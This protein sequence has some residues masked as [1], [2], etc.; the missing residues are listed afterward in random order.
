MPTILALVP[1]LMFGTRIEDAAKRLGYR[2]VSLSAADDFDAVMDRDK[3]ALVIVALDA[4]NWERAVPAA[5]RAGARVLAFG[6]HKNVELLQAA[7]AAGC[8]QVVA[9]SRMAAE[10]P[11]LLKKYVEP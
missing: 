4:A 11:D 7:K 6:S 9:R 10:L 8:D 2:I 5:K 1:D 3:P